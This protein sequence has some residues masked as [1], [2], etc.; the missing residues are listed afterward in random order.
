VHVDVEQNVGFGSAAG[1][2]PTIV[3]RLRAN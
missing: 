1:K 3:G 2:H